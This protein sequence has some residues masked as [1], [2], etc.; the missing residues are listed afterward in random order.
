MRILVTNDDGIDSV[1]LHV[2]ANSLTE[3]GDVVVAAPDTEYSG[4]SAALGALHVMRPEIHRVQLDGVPQAWSVTGPPALCVRL[5]KLGAFGGGFDLVVAGINPGANTGRAVYHSGT[6][7]AVV[8]GRNAGWHGIAVSQA[9]TVGS[10]EGQ[11]WDEMIAGQLW[12]SAGTIAATVAS[13]ILTHPPTEAVALNVNVPNLPLDAIRGWR[14]TTLAEVP[15]RSMSNLVLEPKIGH[16]GAYRVG[17]EWG[18]PIVLPEETDGG[19]V[20]AGF[21]ALTY[22]S[23]ITPVEP[24]DSAKN[25]AVALD[26]LLTR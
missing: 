3:V 4:A 11:A 20:E 19:A 15:I 26:A 13:A 12:D 7:G 17:L 25:A 6:V 8:T 23:P 2:L 21:V 14:Y 10:I 1:G 24:P 5:A 16:E 22:L 9:V 18:E